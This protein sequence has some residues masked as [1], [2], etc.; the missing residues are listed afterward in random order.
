[1]Q[2]SYL[3]TD[4][5]L[6]GLR[7]GPLPDHVV[8]GSDPTKSDIV[9][10]PR[11]G[12]T[13][14]EVALERAREGTYVLRLPARV[15]FTCTLSSVRGERRALDGAR[16]EDG[17][18]LILQAPGSP[19]LRL[20]MRHAHPRQLTAFPTIAGQPMTEGPSAEVETGTPDVSQGRSVFGAEVLRQLSSRIVA[21]S[22]WARRLQHALLAW[23]QGSAW[24]TYTLAGIAV[25]AV[26]ALF[27]V[28]VLM[29]TGM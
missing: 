4:Q 17:D 18:T 22:R 20:R 6:G 29:L 5:T 1:L 7:F 12:V 21:R 2:D 27:S 19:P 9:L 25:T 8:I 16:L 14:G 15:P 23:S 11:A 3:E 24:S 28:V 26:I 10:D 13:G